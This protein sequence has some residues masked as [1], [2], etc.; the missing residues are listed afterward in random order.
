MNNRTLRFICFLICV[1]SIPAFSSSAVAKERRFLFRYNILIKDIPP[2]SKEVRVWVPYP[3][4]NSHQKLLSS[5]M[6]GLLEPSLEEDAEHN[7]KYLYYKLKSPS[8]SSIEISQDYEVE[9]SEYV[10]KAGDKGERELMPEG[11]QELKGLLE[12]NKLVTISPKIK[13]MAASI[14]E[15]KLAVMDKAKAIYDYVYSNVSY[16]K[17]IP[18]WGQGDTERVC[19]IKAGNCT[20]FHS[21]FISLARAS[22]IPTRFIIGFPLPKTADGKIASYHCWAE[23]YEPSLGWVPVDIS[24]AWKDKEKH[25]YFFGTVDENRIEFTNGRDIALKPRQ[26]GEPLNYFIYPYVEIDGKVHDA[27][28]MAFEFQDLEKEV[29]QSDTREKIITITKEMKR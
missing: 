23:F 17:T 6:E 22:G 21:L 19:V 12:P 20:D 4:E 11:P 2:G 15:G 13:E 5:R 14:T 7:N 9:R 28:E 26:I 16:N 18:G 1:L 29:K 25:D 24:E 10:N 8:Q 3:A 27:I